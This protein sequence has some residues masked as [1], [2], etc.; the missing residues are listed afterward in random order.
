M[1]RARSLTLAVS[2]QTE[3]AAVDGHGLA[4]IHANALSR[5]YIHRSS[6]GARTTTA[7][8][9]VG[10]LMLAAKV[11]AVR[12]A[13]KNV[14]RQTIRDATDAVFRPSSLGRPSGPGSGQRRRRVP[15]PA[16]LGRH[17]LLTHAR[18][19]IPRSSSSSSTT[20][21][22]WSF[23]SSS[24]GAGARSHAAR[25]RSSSPF[26]LGTS[27]PALAIS[28]VGLGAPARTFASGAGK[29]VVDNVLSNVPL[30]LRAVGDDWRRGT[31]TKDV[32][33]LDRV[34]WAKTL[35]RLSKRERERAHALRRENARCLCGGGGGGVDAPDDVKAEWR[36]MYNDFWLAA[37]STLARELEHDHDHDQGS[38][39]SSSIVSFQEDNASVMSVPSAHELELQ[40]ARV[41]R[42]R[43]QA[44]EATQT[45][46]HTHT[47]AAANTRYGAPSDA[48]T[49]LV[50]QTAPSEYPL[51][52]DTDHGGVGVLSSSSTWSP[53]D[54][55]D[56]GAHEIL[57]PA[58]LRSGAQLAH[59]HAAH[60]GR[61]N[62]LVD[63][64]RVAG[65]LGDV[66]AEW[67]VDIDNDEDRLGKA[68]RVPA[69]RCLAFRKWAAVDI[70]A[71]LG[72]WGD[73]HGDFYHVIDLDVERRQQQQEE[74][75]RAEQSVIQD[76]AMGGE[77]CMDIWA[78]TN[79]DDDDEQQQQHEPSRWSDAADDD[80]YSVASLP[81]SLLSTPPSG[82]LSAAEWQD[83]TSPPPEEQVRYAR[84]RAYY[85][86]AQPPP[87]SVASRS[88]SGVF[89]PLLSSSSSLS[90]A[91]LES[92]SSWS[93]SSSS[94]VH[95]PVATASSSS[96]FGGS[97]ADIESLAP[98]PR[99]SSPPPPEMLDSFTDSFVFPSVH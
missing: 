98:S 79:D 7:G 58:V 54:H 40:L 82:S 57:T 72:D 61:V 92:R 89:S 81:D 6:L 28:H 87:S 77:S 67:S 41:Q 55:G 33:R 70:R 62:V 65:V 21:T 99:S 75:A 2:Q 17:A 14:L 88:S 15:L 32:D 56:Y 34:K 42:E 76:A 63:R 36:A 71:A 1:R 31:T 12:V 90:P 22:S 30:A 84:G 37:S 35:R 39:P 9:G 74:T 13:L 45:H 73:W 11:R 3:A 91:S 20:T 16:E 46:T 43:D 29:S 52:D 51:D 86:H 60:R 83:A 53:M 44:Q 94:L 85:Y 26:P 66:L 25:Q 78:G 69:K 80:D 38:S 49:L 4:N 96:S 93:E 19:L 59:A 68:R 23:G 27:P 50:V 5:A 64:L 10:H 48:R 24:L 97:A 95:S 47:H 18:S 8:V